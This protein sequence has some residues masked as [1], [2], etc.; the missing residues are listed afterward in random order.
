M[1]PAGRGSRGVPGGSLQGTARTV[2]LSLQRY[3]DAI[4]RI[5]ELIL[6]PWCT[7]P[8]HREATPTPFTNHAAATARAKSTMRTQAPLRTA[9]EMADLRARLPRFP[10]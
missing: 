1:R 9:R 3:N 8:W 5:V 4:M 7:E 2:R 10:D 6:L